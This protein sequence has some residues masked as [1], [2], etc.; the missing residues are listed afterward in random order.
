MDR[1]EFLRRNLYIGMALGLPGGVALGSSESPGIGGDVLT[2]EDIRRA[3]EVLEKNN[4]WLRGTFDWWFDKT[5]D[6]LICV[7]TEE[8]E[9]REVVTRYENDVEVSKTMMQRFPQISRIST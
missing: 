1:R 3:K 9:D 7:Y 8:Y 6:K 2:L 4:K 5:S